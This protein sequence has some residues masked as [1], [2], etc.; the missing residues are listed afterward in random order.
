MISITPLILALDRTSPNRQVWFWVVV[1]VLFTMAGGIAIVA[2]RKRLRAEDDHGATSNSLLDELRASRRSGA[3]SEAEFERAR[4]AITRTLAEAMDAKTIARRTATRK[5]SAQMPGI[6]ESL[7]EREAEA[8]GLTKPAVPIP[9]KLGPSKPGVTRATSA[10][11]AGA[12]ADQRE[13]GEDVRR[14]PPGLDLT[15]APLPKARPEGGSGK[16]GASESE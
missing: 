16:P 12:R 3:I 5:A 15:G 6:L 7:H 10:S 9:S 14:A 13:A 1:L 11:G 8:L 2:L 4:V